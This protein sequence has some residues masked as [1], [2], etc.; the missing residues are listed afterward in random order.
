MIEDI[1]DIGR[2]EIAEGGRERRE[3]FKLKHKQR[4]V[5]GIQRKQ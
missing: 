1:E 5:K 2:T 4:K 3:D